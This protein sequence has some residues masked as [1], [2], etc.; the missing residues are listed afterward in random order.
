M[1]RVEPAFDEVIHAPHRLRIAVMLAAVDT[2]EFQAIRDDLDVADSVLSKQLKVLSEADYV[3]LDKRP[4][5]GRQRTWVTL[6]SS[7]R[8][9]L[10][11]H[12]AELQRLAAIAA[13]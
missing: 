2:M 10:A 3:T 4:G 11:A 8:T 12:L 9:A 5:H 1:A 13:P 7:G 6:T